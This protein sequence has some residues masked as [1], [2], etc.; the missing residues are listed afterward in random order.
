M[1]H[2]SRLRRSLLLSLLL[3]ASQV[4]WAEP[5]AQQDASG[6]SA[7]RR[8]PL[9]WSLGSP[10]TSYLFGTIHIA[11]PRVTTLPPAVAIAFESSDEVRTEI[12]LDAASMA[13]IAQGLML[14]EEQ[15]LSD[16]LP[17]ALLERIAAFLEEQG[18]SLEPF[19]R[20]K[21]WVLASML[22]ILEAQESMLQ[23]PLDQ[24]LYERAVDA[25]K[26]VGGL[27]TIEEQLSILDSLNPQEE[28][29]LLEETL[30][31][32]QTDADYIETLIQLYLSGDAEALLKMV[33]E[34]GEEG[35]PL[36]QKY[37]QRLVE[38]RNAVMA[39]RIQ[40]LLRQQPDRRFFFAVGA[41]HL[42]GDQSIIQLLR[43]GGLI[44]ERVDD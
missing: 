9:L 8:R 15:T 36:A 27:E 11:D 42:G 33:Y 35:D 17:E 3:T 19:E 5:D 20:L 2:R 22:S 32:L 34:F 29:A 28:V 1:H 23:M 40:T 26:S 30:E 38:D 41:G 4:V 6:E 21:P 10:P 25:G 43:D 14:P 16:V 39:Q 24:I 13:Q 18:L 44:L 31:M 12:P 37:G 7:P